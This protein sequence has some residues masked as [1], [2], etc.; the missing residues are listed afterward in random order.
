MRLEKCSNG[1]FYDADKFSVCPHCSEGGNGNPTK[2]IGK[3]ME[4]NV[5]VPISRISEPNKANFNAPAPN[6]PQW[7]ADEEKTQALKHKSLSVEPVVGWLV[8]VT[9]KNCGKD[10]RLKTGRNF[11][12]RNNDMDI[13]LIGD[14]TVSRDK[15]AIVVFEPKHNMFLA[16]PGD[17]KELFYLNEEVVLSAKEMNKND[18]LQ[19]GENTLML[20]PCCDDKFN[21]Q[22]QENKEEV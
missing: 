16:Q 17:S 14:N 5:T 15:H 7:H 10:F 22:E 21:W 13:A 19:I 11:I 3:E 9:G 1:H 2:G 12:G 20:I 18:K 8:C 4:A 6:V